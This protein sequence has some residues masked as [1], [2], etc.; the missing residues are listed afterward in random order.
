MRPSVPQVKPF[1][2]IRDELVAKIEAALKIATSHNYQPLEYAIAEARRYHE[3][4]VKPRVNLG[5]FDAD[6]ARRLDAQLTK[7][8][9]M[10]AVWKAKHNK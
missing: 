7:V 10:L 8:E 5:R 3:E 2:Q 9:T 1:E 4:E 6:L